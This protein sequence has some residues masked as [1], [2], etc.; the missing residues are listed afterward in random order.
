MRGTII[1]LTALALAASLLL[2]ACGKK[3]DPEA[4]DPNQFPHQYPTAETLPES[5]L[6]PPPPPAAP[7]YQPP[8]SALTPYATSTY[9]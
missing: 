2:S 8:P 9:P 7:A 5:T 6:P 4:S 3:G 1:P